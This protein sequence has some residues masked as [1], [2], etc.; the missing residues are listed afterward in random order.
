MQ[1]MPATASALGV[2]AKLAEQNAQGGAKFLRELLIRYRGNA[3][4]ALAAYNAGPGAVEKYKGV[5]PYRETRRYIVKVL[6]EYARQA[7]SAGAIA[8]RPALHTS[9]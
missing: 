7:S 4:L 5:P 9:H 6:R 1:L 3:T 8:N 2:N